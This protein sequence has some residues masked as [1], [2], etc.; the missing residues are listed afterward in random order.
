[1]SLFLFPIVYI[2]SYLIKSTIVS[3][4]KNNNNNN[5]HNM[6]LKND[7]SNPKSLGLWLECQSTRFLECKVGL[8]HQET[9]F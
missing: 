2:F 5:Y 9:L 6:L 3:S 4:P 8:S 7:I 1:M